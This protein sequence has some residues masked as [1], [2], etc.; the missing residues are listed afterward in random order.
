MPENSDSFDWDAFRALGRRMVDDVVLDLSTLREGPVWRPPTPELR[1]A[2]TAPLDAPKSLEAVY[3]DYLRLIAPYA[4]G[5]RHPGFMGWAQGAA[6]PAGVLAELLMASLNMNCGGRDHVGV[7]VERQVA[8]WVRDWFGFPAAAAGLFVTGA[9]QANLIALLAA[10]TRR[11]GTLS[12]REGLGAAG[13]KLRAY[14]SRSVHACVPR[15]MEMAGL[16]SDALRLVATGPDLAI[17]PAALKK[18]IEEDRAAGLTPFLV[19]G[20]A[21]TVDVG[22]FDDLEHLADITREQGL[23]L[24]VDGAFGAQVIH[25]PAH[26]ARLAGLE[27]ADSLA[28]D[29]HKWGQ[30]PYDAGFVLVREERALLDA[31]AGEAAYLAREPEGLAAGGVWPTDIGPDL[32][33]ACRALKAWVVLKVEGRE[34]VAAAVDQGVDLA[35]SLIRRIEREPKLELMAYGGLNIVCFRYRGAADEQDCDGLNRKIVQ[36][37]HILGRVAPSTTQIKGSV[38]IRAAFFNPSTRESDIES[39]VRGV[40]DLGALIDGSD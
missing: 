34:G 16:G 19:V 9:S 3:E 28:F 36:K 22:A 1:Q 30:V 8:G 7:L 14:A 20:C 37:L 11:L 13:L 23:W 40:L 33:R 32:S 31:F 26:R 4:S 27:R 2:L 18:A 38:A 15:A 39:L 24:H 21:G 17:D 25:S 5:N 29:F 12:R 10:R 6:A 35:R